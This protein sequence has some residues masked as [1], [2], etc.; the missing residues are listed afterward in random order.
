MTMMIRIVVYMMM[1][2]VLVMVIVVTG[3]IVLIVVVVIVRTTTVGVKVTVKFMWKAKMRT[4]GIPTIVIIIAAT[5]FL[6]RQLC[7]WTDQSVF[8][9]ELC[10]S[11]SFQDFQKSMMHG[12]ELFSSNS[13]R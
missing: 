8:S 9:T 4:T 11:N 13:S 12:Q 10:D 5:A 6:I 3:F 2:L 1:G 7:L